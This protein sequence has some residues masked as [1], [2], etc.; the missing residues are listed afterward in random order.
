MYLDIFPSLSFIV[1]YDQHYFFPL[2]P[3]YLLFN[4]LL[5]LW[6]FLYFPFLF[7]LVAWKLVTLFLSSKY[8]FLSYFLKNQAYLAYY[9]RKLISFSLS[10]SIRR[11]LRIHEHY[12]LPYPLPNTHTH[13]H[14]HSVNVTLAGIWVLPWHTQGWRWAGRCPCGLS[15]SAAAVEEVQMDSRGPNFLC[16]RSYFG[17]QFPHL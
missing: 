7:P 2:L 13:T 16:D 3:F 5:N 15:V 11:D 17:P 1:F 6:D 9:S 8:S 14:T 4:L 12:S 10:R